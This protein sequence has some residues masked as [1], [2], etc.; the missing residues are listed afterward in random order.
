MKG[1]TDGIR[2]MDSETQTVR[3]QIVSVQEVSMSNASGVQSVSGAAQEQSASMEE[4][5]AETRTLSNLAD[6]LAGE[7][8]V[9]KL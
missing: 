3:E 5:S 6:Q 2:Q 9:F 1:I 4:I 8:K 7:T